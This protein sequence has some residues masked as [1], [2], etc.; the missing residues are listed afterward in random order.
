MIIKY[1]VRYYAIFGPALF[2]KLLLFVAYFFSCPRTE[3]DAICWTIRTLFI[4]ITISCLENPH[5]LKNFQRPKI[6][7]DF[8]KF[9]TNKEA[10]KQG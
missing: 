6:Y 2:S 10:T 5:L 3:S 8:F 4:V 7:V 9:S 1:I